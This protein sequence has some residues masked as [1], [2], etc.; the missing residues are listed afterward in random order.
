MDENRSIPRVG[1]L[2]IAQVSKIAQFGAYCKLLEYN[3]LDVFLPIREVSSGWIK[4]IH[5]FIREGQKLVVKVTYHDKERNTIDISLK[6]VT[7]KET[8]EKIRAFNLENRLRALFM[9]SVKVAKLDQKKEQ[10]VA[11]ALSEFGSFTNL[12]NH[13]NQDTTE[14]KGSALP[15][16][17]KEAFTTSVASTKKKKSYK[18]SYILTLTT[19]NTKNG[20]AELRDIFSTVQQKGVTVSY[21]SAPKYRMLAESEDFAEAKNMIKSAEE[22]IRSKLK[23]G[24]FELEKEKLK[25]EKEDIMENI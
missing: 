14:F 18:V 5:E 9:Q 24:V 20:A 16:K 6:K 19:Y 21:I 12:V 8:K 7:P 11:T 2:V 25:K 1:E 3:N 15:A 22:V 23:K 10:M 17:L 4:N 13:V